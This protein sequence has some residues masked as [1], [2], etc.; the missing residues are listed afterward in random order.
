MIEKVKH[1]G[2]AVKNIDESIDNYCKILGLSLVHREIIPTRKVEI[3]ILDGKNISIELVSDN[4][5]GHMIKDFIEKKGEGLHHI[6][7]QVEDIKSEIASLRS[8]GVKLIDDEPR[9]G[10]HSNLVAFVHPSCFNG[11]LIEFCQE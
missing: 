1:V 8:Q 7:F 10:A 2:I 11:V 6:A 3:A 5:V 9:I 4:G